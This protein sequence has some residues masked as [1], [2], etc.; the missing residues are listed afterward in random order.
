MNRLYNL[1]IPAWTIALSTIGCSLAGMTQ[2][3]P[4]LA[5]PALQLRSPIIF[6]QQ[7]ESNDRPGGRVGGGKRPP[8]RDQACPQVD[9]EL[10]AIVPAKQKTLPNGIHLE[11][12]QGVTTGEHLTF[13]F[14]VPYSTA[15]PATLS[16]VQTQPLCTKSAEV[17]RWAESPGETIPAENCRVPDS[18]DSG[19]AL[20]T[21][22]PVLQ[23]DSLY[24]M[25]HTQSPKNASPNIA[26]ASL[27]IPVAIAARFSPSTV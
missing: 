18:T 23:S 5:R 12:V 14:Y 27:D 22:S 10:T 8:L 25:P 2:T 6:V 4:T 13:W 11:F 19:D 20:S 9:R 3:P 21:D 16:L 17:R 1:T 7:W 24:S 26:A 15:L